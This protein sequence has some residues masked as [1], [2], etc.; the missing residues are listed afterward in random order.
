[1]TNPDLDHDGSNSIAEIAATAML[2][3]LRASVADS[4][5]TRLYKLRPGSGTL[6]NHEG[7]VAALADLPKPVAIEVQA[8][9]DV[10]VLEWRRAFESSPGA[11]V[12]DYDA[13]PLSAL[14]RVPESG[15]ILIIASEDSLVVP[16]NAIRELVAAYRVGSP[17]SMASNPPDRIQEALG[18]VSVVEIF[19]GGELLDFE[20]YHK[21][22]LDDSADDI[23]RRSGRGQQDEIS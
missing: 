17:Y 3:I 18:I 20:E 7:A 21:L 5:E 2:L 23:P 14:T 4:R 15:S 19:E 8:Q 13:H 10:L 22:L 12:A 9:H 16:P 6:L 1:M 11:N